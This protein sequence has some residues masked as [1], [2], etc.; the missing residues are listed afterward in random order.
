MPP[1]LLVVVLAL[2]LAPRGRAPAPP[3]RNIVFVI[4]DD[5]RYDGLGCTGSP[6]AR[7]PHI[8][9]LAAEGLRL[10]NF[11]CCT[12]LCSP[13]RASFLTGLYP[14]R[15]GVVNNDR[16]G[17]DVI[18]H[19]LYTFPRMLREAGY[20]TGFVG[21]WHM[22]LDDSRRPGFDTWVSFKGQGL[23]RDPVVNVNGEQRQLDG[24]MTD[25]LNRWAVEFVRKPRA[26]PFCLY[27]SHK[28][29]HIPYLPAPRHEKLYSD[30][31]PA[32]PPSA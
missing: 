24:Y 1:L 14:H 13:S 9:R 6:F 32:L 8:D 15:H 21:K 11:F 27:L 29:V 4:A 28:A 20:E 26:K 5:L 30:V 18:S 23:Y 12:P 2:V 19:T 25:H 16:V 22:G 3:R 17:L 31:K 7:T 10:T